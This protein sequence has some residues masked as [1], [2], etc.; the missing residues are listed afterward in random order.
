MP[1]SAGARGAVNAARF[2]TAFVQLRASGVLR[3]AC[4]TAPLFRLGL[5]TGIEAA[6]GPGSQSKG[7][8]NDDRNQHLVPDASHLRGD[9]ERHEEVLAADRRSLPLSTIYE[10][11]QRGEFPQPFALLPRCVVW[12]LGEIEAWLA[13]QRSTP[14]V[15]A[16]P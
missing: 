9:Q 3:T 6:I 7:Q 5:E 13:S 8:D 2:R 15:R 14:I 12:D 10:M 4:V 16:I 11:E 1:G